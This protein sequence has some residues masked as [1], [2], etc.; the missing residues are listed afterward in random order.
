MAK[1]SPTFSIDVT[2]NFTAGQVSNITNPGVAF[3]LIGILASGTT[4]AGITVASVTTGAVVTT[5]GT[6]RVVKDTQA[7]PVN[8]GSVCLMVDGATSFAATDNI[9]ITVATAA[10]TRVTLLCRSA[11]AQ[12]W[13]NSTPA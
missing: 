10:V 6:A 2:D 3:E 8:A 1:F 11:S 12:T 7:T 13:T 9:R 4:D 5:A